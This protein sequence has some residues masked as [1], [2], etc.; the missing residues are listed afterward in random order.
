MEEIIDESIYTRVTTPLSI[1]SGYEKVP[2]VILDY[3]ADRGTRIH[4]YCELYAHDML[5]GQVDEDCIEYV[6]AFVNWY[7]AEVR[8]VLFTEERL[9]CNDLLI[10]GMPDMVCKLKTRPPGFKPVLIDIKT[11]LKYSKTWD[12]QTAAYKYLCLKNGYEIGDRIVVHLHKDANFDTI[13]YKDTHQDT[14]Y[15]E[16]LITYQACLKAYRYFS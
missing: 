4:K 13:E 1:Y 15:D 10:Q 8:E 14:L 6:Q 5:F 11:S 16:H 7:D 2:E 3:A 9:Y 12:L